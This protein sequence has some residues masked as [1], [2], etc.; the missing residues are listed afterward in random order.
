M[1]RAGLATGLAVDR[2]SGPGGRSYGFATLPTGQPFGLS[3][4]TIPCCVSGEAAY[5]LPFYRP[6]SITRKA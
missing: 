6:R 4:V 2:A 3:G 1:L 5:L